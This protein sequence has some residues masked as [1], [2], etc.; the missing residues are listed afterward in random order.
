[1][2]S[3]QLSVKKEKEKNMDSRLRGND[4]GKK[5][6]KEKTWI[7]ACA[8]MTKKKKQKRK[9]MDSR[10]RGNDKGKKKQKKKKNSCLFV[11]ISGSLFLLLLTY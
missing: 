11:S 3:Y 8:G 1:V 6:E 9:N 2:V 7:P 10:L 5:T 4:K